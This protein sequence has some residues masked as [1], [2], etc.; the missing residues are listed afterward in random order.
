MQCT[1]EG[2][3]FSRSD[4]LNNHELKNSLF[5][6]AEIC[7]NLSQFQIWFYKEEI[8]ALMTDGDLLEM[9]YTGKFPASVQILFLK[10][11]L[12]RKKGEINAYI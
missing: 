8:V 11:I 12:K 1:D 3:V 5:K 9:I 7:G 10:E 6:M 4:M 2:L